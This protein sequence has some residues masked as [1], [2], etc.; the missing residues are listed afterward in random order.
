MIKS[1]IDKDLGLLRSDK[2]IHEFH[3]PSGDCRIG[4]ETKFLKV[5]FIIDMSTYMPYCPC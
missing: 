5:K 3:D 2:S 4:T 1:A